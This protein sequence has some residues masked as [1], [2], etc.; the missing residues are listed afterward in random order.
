MT[1]SPRTL[2]IIAAGG[3]F[4]LIFGGRCRK[5]GQ[6][7]VLLP[8]RPQHEVFDGFAG[9]FAF[10]EDQLHLLGDGHFDPVQAGQAEHGARGEDAFSDLAAQAV[11]DLR[12]VA[13][14]TQRLTDRPV[15]AESRC[16]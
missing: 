10:V 14:L 7:L 9:V 13:A 16:R 1:I 6:S 11:E 4:L 12:E 3:R 5:D 8:P 15:A 2:R